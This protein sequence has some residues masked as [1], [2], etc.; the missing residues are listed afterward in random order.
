MDAVSV[1]SSL[2]T[3]SAA[4]LSS[5]PRARPSDADAQATK[6]LQAQPLAAEAQQNELRSTQ[7]LAE[8]QAS[9]RSRNEAE[10]TRPSVNLNGQLVG[11]RVNTTA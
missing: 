6:A 1:T 9:E 8:G 5:T 4:T 11:T 7:V 10:R 2:S 3:A